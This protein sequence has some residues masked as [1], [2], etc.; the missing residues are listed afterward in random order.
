MACPDVDDCFTVDDDRC[1]RA[2]FDA[3]SEILKERLAHPLESDR[4][5]PVNLDFLLSHAS[6]ISAIRSTFAKEGETSRPVLRARRRSNRSIRPAAE[7][8]Q[9]RRAPY[10]VNIRG[11]TFSPCAKVV[12]DEIHRLANPSEVLKIAADHFP[13]VRV[14]ATDTSTLAAKD[15][16]NDTLAGRKREVCRNRRKNVSR[17]LCTRPNHNYDYISK[18]W[19]DPV[20]PSKSHVTPSN[21]F[22][23]FRESTIGTSCATSARNC[24]HVRCRRVV[25]RS[26]CSCPRRLVPGGSS[27]SAHGTAF[28]RSTRSEGIPCSSWP[29]A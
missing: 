15:K 2:D 10:M 12:L 24:P 17:S 18:P 29:S 26:R 14:I 28:V 22:E 16:F 27:A 8:S 23:H 19:R 9:I 4:A 7:D 11:R 1:R 3:I 20:S 25:T 13:R 6:A 21:T 5:L